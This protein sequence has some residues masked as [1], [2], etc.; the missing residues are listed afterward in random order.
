MKGLHVAVKLVTKRRF[1]EKSSPNIFFSTKKL[2]AAQTE[3]L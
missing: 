3:D 2:G 1:V